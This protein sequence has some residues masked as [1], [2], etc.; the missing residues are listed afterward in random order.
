MN[1]G[2]IYMKQNINFITEAI[3]A[4]DLIGKKIHLALFSKNRKMSF[5]KIL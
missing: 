1:K 3:T 5:Y 4:S 2:K